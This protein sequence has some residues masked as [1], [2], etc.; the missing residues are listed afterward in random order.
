MN[1]GFD[2]ELALRE[3][4]GML[5]ALVNRLCLPARVLDS[6]R[7]VLYE[8]GSRS[9]RMD[10]H[11]MPGRCGHGDVALPGR[12]C[13]YCEIERQMRAGVSKEMRTRLA[14][15]DCLLRFEP[16]PGEDGTVAVVDAILMPRTG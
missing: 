14:G 13:P 15:L 1:R 4:E 6:E 7:R 10:S 16:V 5:K 2:P 9:A 8:N 12:G 3:A 11:E